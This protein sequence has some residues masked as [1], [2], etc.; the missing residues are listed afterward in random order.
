MKQSNTWP[1]E[2]EHNGKKYLV[3]PCAIAANGEVLTFDVQNVTG[4]KTP[5]LKQGSKTHSLVLAKALGE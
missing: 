1:R 2:V 3:T 4:W 5:H